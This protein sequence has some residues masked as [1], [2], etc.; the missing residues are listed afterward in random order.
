MGTPFVGQ[1]ILAAFNFPPKGYLLA[2]GQ[3][4]PINQNQ[5]LFSLLGTTFGG[6]GIR[7]FLLPNLQ[8]RTPVGVGNGIGYGELAGVESYTLLPSDVPAHLH[9]LSA[10]GAAASSEKPV[11]GAL[12]A[13][14]G[15][16]AFAPPGSPGA[17]NP[18]TVSTVGGN[19]PHENRQPFLVMTWCIALNGIFPSR[20]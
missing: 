16:N 2:N 19:Q 1:L 18:A 7:T 20:N 12:L 13:G 3:T 8:G 10:S 11:G 9:V 6:D 4:L 5:A 17:M 14:Q 15:V